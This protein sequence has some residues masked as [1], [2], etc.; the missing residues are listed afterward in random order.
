[1]SRLWN[2]AAKAARSA[3]MRKVLAQEAA[4]PVGNSPEQFAAIIE[5][6]IST[7]KK[8]VDAAGIKSE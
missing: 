4:E 6:E 3:E 7:W 5:R 1:V 2:E 8:V